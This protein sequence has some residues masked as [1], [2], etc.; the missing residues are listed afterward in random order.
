MAKEKEFYGLHHVSIAVAD[1]EEA[2]KFYTEQMGF[3]LEH[4]YDCGEPG[5][6][7][8]DS[9]VSQNGFYL[10]LIQNPGDDD[11][12]TQA[13]ATANHFALYVKDIR[14]TVERL[15]KDPRLVFESTEP[16]LVPGFGTED[17]YSVMFRGI[18]GERIELLEVE[19][20]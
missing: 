2:I 5:A 4:R 14:K 13:M 18:N 12:R 17:L 16:A 3:K 10:E 7:V 1:R 15:S 19:D 11:V 8:Y 20:L 6:M 9:I